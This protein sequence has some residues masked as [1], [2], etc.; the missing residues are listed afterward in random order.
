MV[1]EARN[2]VG[3]FS[4]V[5]TRAPVDELKYCDRLCKPQVLSTWRGSSNLFAD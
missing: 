1:A 5:K 2:F 3:S 4:A